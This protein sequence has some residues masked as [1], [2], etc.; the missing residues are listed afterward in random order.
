MKIDLTWGLARLLNFTAQIAIAI[1]MYSA[2]NQ[3]VVNSMR[4][5]ES[6]AVV[7]LPRRRTG[8]S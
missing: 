6:T 1:R 2:Y 8:D 4:K 5:C 3:R 7:V